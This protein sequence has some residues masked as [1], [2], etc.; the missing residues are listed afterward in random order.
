M[1]LELK[2][3]QLNRLHDLLSSNRRGKIPYQA[4]PDKVKITAEQ[5]RTVKRLL[6]TGMPL[7]QIM[8]ETE[9]SEY[10]VRGVRRGQY[11][12]LLE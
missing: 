4:R 3:E 12:F 1:V 11:N 2:P 8:K 10:Y 5:V 9:L 6:G 7:V